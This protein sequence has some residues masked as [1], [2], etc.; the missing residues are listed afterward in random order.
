MG[1]AALQQGS[2]KPH[3]ARICSPYLPPVSLPR[4]LL[5]PKRYIRKVP[6]CMHFIHVSHMF[7]ARSGILFRYHW[8]YMYSLVVPLRRFSSPDPGQNK[9]EALTPMQHADYWF[10]PVIIGV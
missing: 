6:G 9:K 5:Q 8:H 4:I 7:E 10:R 2:W 3:A 1:F